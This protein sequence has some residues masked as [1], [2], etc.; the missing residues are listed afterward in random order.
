[1]H[2]Y[3]CTRPMLKPK[4][5]DFDVERI[6]HTFKFESREYL[7]VERNLAGNIFF[8]PSLITTEWIDISFNYEGS[9]VIKYLFTWFDLFFKVFFI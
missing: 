7:G 1:M 8:Q 5:L 4:D 6:D 9:T 3:F 2:A